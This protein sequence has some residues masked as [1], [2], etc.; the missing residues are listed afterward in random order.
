MQPNILITGA[1]G[2]V[3][4]EI[5]KIALR[6]PLWRFDFMTR[7]HFDLGK[8]NM[9]KR[10]LEQKNYDYIINAGAYTAVDK[11]ESE[12]ETAFAINADGPRHIVNYMNQH[13]TLIH[14]STDYLYH[15]NPGRPIV[16]TDETH[17]QG[18]YAQSKLSGEKAIEHSDRNYIILRTS[19]VYS[20]FGHNFVKTMLRL[21]RE[22]KEVSVVS[23]QIVSPT[24]ALDLAKAVCAII[25]RLENEPNNQRYKGIYNL[26]SE[27]Q[28]HWADFARTIFKFSGLKCKVHDISSE[29]FNAAA[30]RPPWSILSNDKFLRTFQFK[31]PFWKESLLNC[32]KEM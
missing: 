15:H 3:G 28:V 19:A 7:R 21:G 17:P 23:D 18:I 8:K 1:S 29:E 26:T 27:G 5:Q 25:H 32:L 6:Y 24:Y 13:T 9:I 2:Q 10:V 11:A 4:S 14:F 22:R 12:K 30:P 16:E 20:T 31:M